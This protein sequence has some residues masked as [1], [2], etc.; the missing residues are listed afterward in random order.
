MSSVTQ[1]GLSDRMYRYSLGLQLS[2]DLKAVLLLPRKFWDKRGQH[3]GYKW[4]PH[5]L[6]V[7]LQEGEPETYKRRYQLKEVDLAVRVLDLMLVCACGLREQAPLCPCL[8]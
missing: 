5:I 7:S 6:S 2:T 1:A 4:V 8:L 3:G